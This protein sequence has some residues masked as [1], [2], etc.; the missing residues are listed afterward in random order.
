[1]DPV[2]GA[3]LAQSAM[4]TGGGLFSTILTSRANKKMAEYAYSKDL[5]M[6]N[7]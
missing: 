5:E 2:T 7:R 6:W 1:M 3:I 4:Q